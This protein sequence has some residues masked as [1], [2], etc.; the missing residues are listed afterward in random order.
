MNPLD[1]L[2]CIILGFC[3]IRGIFRG[4]I[5]EITSLIGVFVG[6]YVAYTYYK[7]VASWLSP[8]IGSEP[9]ESIVAFLLTFAV[10]FF[11]LGLIGIL[12]KHLLKGTSLGWTDRILGSLLGL[13][14][15]L[16]IVSVLFIPITTYLPANASVIRNSA[17]APYVSVVSD[18]IVTA[19]PEEMKQRFW[20]KV[21]A[22]RMS[23][24][25]G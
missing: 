2:I 21:N 7:V 11:A 6:F 12:L 14:K 5:K 15:A 9:Y 22:L 25:S 4:S 23:W 17:L 3:L 8:L 16:L 19:V 24:K 18:K 1:I 10:F 13:V 20:E